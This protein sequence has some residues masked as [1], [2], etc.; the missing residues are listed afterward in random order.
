MDYEVR[1]RATVD[2]DT[3]DEWK[4]KE[5]QKMLD[6]MCDSELLAVIFRFD[7]VKVIKE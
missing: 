5:A 4:P 2:L 7:T 1:I 6:R 3:G